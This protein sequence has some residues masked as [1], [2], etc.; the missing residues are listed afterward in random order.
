[1]AK[2]KTPT[3]QSNTA[4]TPYFSRSKIT[5]P[6][7]HTGGIERTQLV[8]ELSAYPKTRKLTVLQAPAGYG[9][10][11]TLRQI[12]ERL[13]KKGFI[14]IWLNFDE[15]D[16]DLSRALMVFCMALAQYDN[17]YSKT[18]YK[19]GEEVLAHQIMESFRGMSKP[20][21]LFFDNLE[22]LKN[23]AVLGVMARGIAALPS[24]C[25]AFVSSRTQPSIGLARLASK[26]ELTN[27]N[28]SELSFTKSETKTL[29]NQKDTSPL[30]AQQIQTLHSRTD[31]WPAALKLAIFALEGSAN[32]DNLISNFSGTNASVAAY[33]A[34]E[35]LAS[36]SPDT[37]KFLLQSSILEEIDIEICNLVLQREDSLTMLLAL[38]QRNLFINATDEKNSLFRYH[39][40]FHDFLKSQLLT[41]DLKGSR[42]LHN[43][44]YQAYIDKGRPIPAIHHALQSD[45]IN[46]A[47]EL[48]TRH[49]D[50]L[51][52][53]GR[54]GLLTKLLSQLPKQQ[55]DQN[56]N[57]KLIYALC[58]T[59]TRGPRQAYEL[60]EDL[61]EVDLP[62]EPAAYL[63]ALRTTQ[64]GMMDRI[65]EA[66]SLGLATLRKV[67][68]EFHNA[69]VILSQAL[70][71]TSIILGD[72]EQAH[73]FS[74]QSRY[75]S[76]SRINFFNQTLAESA[77]SSIDLMTGH[78]KQAN[79]R[80]KTALKLQS[81]HTGTQSRRGISM[82]NIQ[83][84]EISY[85]QDECREAHDLLATNS[86][87]IQDIGPPDSLITALI[88]LSRI[89]NYEGDYEHA[90]QLLIELEN[91]GH[92][93]K[94]PR[95]IA[96]ARLERAHLWLA[97]GDIKGAQQQ[98][99]QAQSTFDWSGADALWYTANDTLTP[100]IVNLRLLTRTGESEE[101][102]LLARKLLIIAEREQRLRRALKLRILLAEALYIN[103]Q[104][105]SSF[106]TMSKAIDFAKE[107]GFVRTFLEEGNTLTPIF[108]SM[109]IIHPPFDQEPANAD[110][111]HTQ[112]LE[113]QVIAAQDKVDRLTNK[114]ME[115]LLVLSQGLSNISMAEK[116]FI[117]EST[118]RT[119]LR[120]INM[121]LNAKNRTEAVHTARRIGLIS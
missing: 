84:A 3:S 103:G 77:E 97:Q 66:H 51:L 69:R 23:P 49:A 19:L 14:T 43:R 90:L 50:Q 7:L 96:S 64:L 101:A 20:A 15:G 8:D 11:T 71:Q 94:L 105:K 111:G 48:L 114:E 81:E 24:T 56:I 117:S 68:D 6:K 57:L 73:S 108:N 46:V 95:V 85:E 42:L 110:P 80:I 92:R 121:K 88:I 5:P 54:I 70:T 116:L 98:L 93:L 82:A 29:L 83:L 63:L 58:V 104:K 28:A 61:N 45:D 109:E 60:L 72:H 102:V 65:E 26:E 107:Q 25:R 59:Y 37:Q 10:T 9:K 38:Q 2:K 52:A 100:D 30:S 47:V 33:L 39:S 76:G 40:L 35:T 4:D 41:N 1:M 113:Q 106:R 115:V 22:S 62:A 27:V 13:Q 91:S 53:T 55:L 112:P 12:M 89:V 44:A 16:N 34:E 86:A 118:V 32:A 119:H 74:D 78:L 75:S 21:A 87:L 31:G 79:H 67:D 36:L 120:N 99:K 18:S 17:A